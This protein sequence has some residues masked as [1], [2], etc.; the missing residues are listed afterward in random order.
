MELLAKFKSINESRV[1]YIYSD[2]NKQLN[3]FSLDSS[4]IRPFQKELLSKFIDLLHVNDECVELLEAKNS[5]YAIYYDRK[6]NFKHYIK[7]GKEDILMFFI[8]NGVDAFDYK[9]DY[10]DYD[11]NEENKE[12]KKESRS[13]RVL[14]KFIA[15]E[16]IFIMGYSAMHAIV[17]NADAILN[18]LSPYVSVFDGEMISIDDAIDF[19]NDSSYL[20]EDYKEFLGNRDLFNDIMPYYEGTY[21]QA[22]IKLKLDQIRFDYFDRT[23]S[24]YYDGLYGYYS[25][26]KPS[27]I[28]IFEECKDKPDDH[29]AI[30]AHEF[31]HLLQSNASVYNYLIETTA[32][33]FAEEYFDVA[34]DSSYDKGV[35]SLKLLVE[36]I[37]IDPILKGVFGGDYTDFEN[38]LMN[39]LDTSDFKQIVDYMSKRPGDVVDKEEEIRRIFSE[40]YM[41]MY[42]QDIRDDE[43]ILYSILYEQDD[44]SIVSD[45]SDRRYYF[46]RS[47]MSEKE[48]VVVQLKDLFSRGDD[49]SIFVKED[50]YLVSRQLESDEYIQYIG[51]DDVELGY[52]SFCNNGLKIGDEYIIYEHTYID[53]NGD[54][55]YTDPVCTMSILEAI[56]NDYLG[57]KLYGEVSAN[58]NDTDL[59]LD[60]WEYVYDSNGQKIISNSSYNCKLTNAYQDNDQLI[61]SRKSIKNRFDVKIR[62]SLSLVTN[63]MH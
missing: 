25:T 62:E 13:F 30:V 50:K 32:E 40:L 61:I 49:N 19:I 4:G 18:T 9:L 47:K 10:I 37:G 22:E 48:N 6:T 35:N 58:H 41:N 27:V 2:H 52:E 26:L 45:M 29:K 51:N 14:K 43:N 21:M 60:G 15:A 63:N 55:R 3:G 44:G 34:I 17:N 16:L 53:A 39:N 38:I 54:I 23:D 20:S 8:N 5:D 31:I 28:N 11:Q 7:D 24:N 46:N 33:L 1:N 12:D 56:E 42:G 59:L 36:I 57:V